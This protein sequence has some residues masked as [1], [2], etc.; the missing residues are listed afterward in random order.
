M[1][2]VIGLLNLVL[3]LAYAT[4]G[5]IT[6]SEMRRGWKTMG[7]S[8]FGAAWILMAFTCGPHHLV[9]ASHLLLE[10]RSGGLFDLVAVSVGFP[11]GVVFLSL[12]VEAW[13]GGRGDRF[14][15]G[16]PRW[17][18]AIP[19]LSASYLTILLTWVVQ[20]EGS[21]SFPR[22]VTPNLLLVG[23]YMAIGYVVTRTQMRNR[24]ALHGWSVSG[25][26]LAL[27]F[28]TCAVM[29]GVYAMYAAQGL[30]GLDWHGWLID[31]LAVPA[32]LYFLW[33]VWNLHRATI[34]DWNRAIM[35]AVP[36]RRAAVV[37]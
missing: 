32:G 7:F 18:Q 11:A 27:I 5:F 21:L 9:H 15:S 12:R 8:H 35:D 30:Y 26:S 3:G 25:L 28:P 4:Y 24:A 36:D 19:A 17:V 34:K 20:Q 13:V 6:I 29:H 16:S 31:W 23:V 1:T 10:G 33:V 2:L 22:Q 14:I 37:S